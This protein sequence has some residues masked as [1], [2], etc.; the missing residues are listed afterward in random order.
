MAADLDGTPTAAGGPCLAA[1]TSSLAQHPAAVWLAGG[2]ER[3]QCAEIPERGSAIA[4]QVVGLRDQLGVTLHL[5]VGCV[6]RAAT[7]PGSR[8]TVAGFSVPAAPTPGTGRP[9]SR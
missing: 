5:L 1:P 8:Y 6:L 3:Q 9:S 4:R 7:R 2:L